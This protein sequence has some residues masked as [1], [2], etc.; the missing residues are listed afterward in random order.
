MVL[1]SL[2]VLSRVQGLSPFRG[3]VR[4]L[5]STDSV[6]IFVGL[7]IE[8]GI[9]PDGLEYPRLEYPRQKGHRHS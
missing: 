1:S 7:A 8:L 6:R 3:A 2:S 4:K 5:M 9:G